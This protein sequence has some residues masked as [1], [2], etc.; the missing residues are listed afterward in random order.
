MSSDY[1]PK[2]CRGTCATSYCAEWGA[3]V[4][5][6]FLCDMDWR[7]LEGIDLSTGQRLVW[8]QTAQLVVIVH[9]DVGR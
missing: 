4:A 5:V 3:G 6:D 1:R 8:G 7:T 9:G 2:W